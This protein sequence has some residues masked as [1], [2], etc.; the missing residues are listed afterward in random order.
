MILLLSEKKISKKKLSKIYKI[1]NLTHIKE[2]LWK[3]NKTKKIFSC[4]IYINYFGCRR[5]RVDDRQ[6]DTLNGFRSSISAFHF[7]FSLI[8]INTCVLK[9]NHWCQ[10]EKSTK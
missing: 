9:I 3:Q 7:H 2:I 5:R 4:S 1:K 8:S 10:C 6:T